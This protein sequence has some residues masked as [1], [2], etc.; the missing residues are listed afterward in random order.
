MNSGLGLRNTTIACNSCFHHDNNNS[1]H[2]PRAIVAHQYE[3][4][5]VSVT[6]DLRA[7]VSTTSNMSST[8][9]NHLDKRKFLV[10]T[11]KKKKLHGLHMIELHCYTIVVV[12]TVPPEAPCGYFWV[13]NMC[14]ALNKLIKK[15]EA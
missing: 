3:C 12:I 5:G 6:M 11:K 4:V 8:S 10:C 2:S 9:L 14:Q 15:T 13:L 1:S 7:A